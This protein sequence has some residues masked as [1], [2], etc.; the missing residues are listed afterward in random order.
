[1]SAAMTFAKTLHAPD[2][3]AAGLVPPE[4]LAELERVAAR[5]AV[6]AGDVEHIDRLAEA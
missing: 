6:A 5:Y 4:R 1:M 3:A 2:L